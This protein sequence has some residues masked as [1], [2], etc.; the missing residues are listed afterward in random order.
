MPRSSTECFPSRAHCLVHNHG[1]IAS[2]NADLPST[3]TGSGGGMTVYRMSKKGGSYLKSVGI[4]QM[5]MSTQS[6]P[7]RRE[8]IPYTKA[9]HKSL[10]LVSSTN[11][12]AA[13][14][15][16]SK[17]FDYKPAGTKRGATK[18]QDAHFKRQPRAGKYS[19]VAP[20]KVKIHRAK[21]FTKGASIYG[22]GKVLPVLGAGF[23]IYDV[24]RADAPVTKVVKDV[25]W[26]ITNPVEF[27]Y[28]ATGMGT[29]QRTSYAG[30][31]QRIKNIEYRTEF[32]KSL[33]PF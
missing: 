4:E 6:M 13:R 32:L 29:L 5:A 14:K 8:W 31:T 12:M 9:Q 17:Q 15:V 11:P 18:R 2:A 22:A 1:G 21:K 19:R 25:V 27:S 26:A 7:A 28:E 3:S 30:E 16:S 10:R 20:G 23:Y 24:A 33:N